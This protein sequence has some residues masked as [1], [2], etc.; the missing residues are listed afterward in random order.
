MT[1]SQRR[2]TRAFVAA[3]VAALVLAPAP[4][5]AQVSKLKGP[6]AQSEGVPAQAVPQELVTSLSSDIVSIQSNFT[7]T[8]I[9]IFGQIADGM[10]K[11]HPDAKYDLAITVEGPSQDITTRRKDRFLGIWINRHYETFQ[12]VPSFYAV[13]TTREVSELAPRDVLDD[14]AIGLY[15]LNLPVSGHSGV[16]VND[17]DDFR[18]AFLELRQQEGLYSERPGAIR[19]LTTTMFRTTVPLPANIPVGAYK[20]RSFL[21]ENGALLSSQEAQL[22][23]GKVGFEQVTYNLSRNYP[24]FYGLLAVFLAVATGWLAGV[25][26]RRD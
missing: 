17:R 24:L 22:Y 5:G 19:F 12:N 16:P 13:A 11:S 14:N 2:S 18:K 3:A 21:F 25:I 1:P 23:V 4:S 9:V 8:E 20:V 7:G 10:Q 6:A 26:F 15:H